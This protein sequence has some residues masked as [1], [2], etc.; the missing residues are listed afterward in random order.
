MQENFNFNGQLGK[1]PPEPTYY[2]PYIPYGFTE[3]NY[4]EKKGIKKASH[5]AGISLIALEI[6]SLLSAFIFSLFAYRVNEERTDIIYV[7]N[8]AVELV[9][10]ILVSIFIFT[11]PFVV[12]YKL[13]DFR[14]SDFVSLKKSEKRKAVPLFFLGI[15]FSAFS[16][17][18]SGYF[19]SFLE[20]FGISDAGGE[21]ENPTGIF[22][23]LLYFLAIAVTPALVE[24]FA[25][26]G[27]ILGTLKKYG[28]GFSILVSAVLF[29]LMHANL[30]QIPFAFLMGLI[31]G[32]SVIKT[33]SLRVSISIHFFNNSLSCILS[34]IPD[35]V[36]AIYVNIGF[37]VF[38]LLSLIIGIMFMLT[39]KKGDLFC[40]KPADTESTLTK[41]QVWF[42]SS[43]SII[44]FVLIICAK[45]YWF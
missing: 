37:Y 5:A 40:V 44:V 23:F 30:Q 7:S 43:A 8:L 33:G 31:L 6:I 32:Y 11:V 45:V 25:C 12:V 36:P 24:E 10:Q 27:L 29:S 39:D 9:F 19:S 1:I 34:Y 14:I 35:S 38:M 16:Q 13:F 4:S 15:G 28:E 22:G 42:Y 17:L 26:R 20:N 41:K 3:K 21:L 18:L 2:R